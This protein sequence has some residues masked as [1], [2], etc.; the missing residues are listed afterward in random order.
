MQLP[1]VSKMS[2]HRLVRQNERERGGGGV[3]P[4]NSNTLGGITQKQ[5][6]PKSGF[7]L[8]SQFPYERGIC[9][10]VCPFCC[11][12]FRSNEG[13]RKKTPEL[14]VLIQF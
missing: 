12:D 14:N 9:L 8:Y 3:T 10:C 13:D 4:P 7:S 5:T 2:S 1:F 11:F 6:W